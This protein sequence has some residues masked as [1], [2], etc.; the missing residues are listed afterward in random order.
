MELQEWCDKL[1]AI[2]QLGVRWRA[3]EINA[4]YGTLGLRDGDPEEANNLVC[5]ALRD[6][7]IA[8]DAFHKSEKQEKSR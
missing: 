6:L 7:R 1:E 5:E 8:L 3:A 2:V 4:G